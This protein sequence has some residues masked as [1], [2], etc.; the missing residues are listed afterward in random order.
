MTSSRP[1][2]LLALL[3]DAVTAAPLAPFLTDL[4]TARTWTYDELWRG[5]RHLAALLSE[6]GVAAGDRV[7]LL[8][9]NDPV[10]FP[11]LF[12]C[13]MT[14][15]ILV[16]V[17]RDNLKSELD[18]IR[19]DAKPVLELRDERYQPADGFSLPIAWRT[20]DAPAAPVAERQEDVLI[21]YTSGTTGNAKGVTLSQRNL[22]TMAG[23]FVSFYRLRPGQRF[24]SML[25]FYHI[26]A[27]MITG[28]VCIAAQ[29][30]VHL[31]D[32]YGFTNAR[33]I[34]DMVEANGINILSL[35]PSI[36][37][38][39]AQLNPSG[40]NRVTSSLE[41]CFCGTAPLSEHLWRAFETLFKVPVY[42]GYGLTETTTWATMT[43]PDARK[44]YDTV[45]VPVGCEIRI[46]GETTGE[47]LIKS[48]I[49]MRGYY[50]KKKLTRKSLC[51][52]WYHSGDV[53]YLDHDGQLVVVGRTK[54]IIKRRG[55]LI[56]P[57]AIDDSLRRSGLVLDSCT[58]GVPDELA[59]ERVVTACVLSQA[60][61]GDV[62]SYLARE[63]SP[64]MR[65]DE[66]VPVHAIPRNTVGKALPAKVRDLVTGD[67]AERVVETFTRSKISR[68]PSEHLAEIQAMI[69]TA[70]LADTRIVLVG[71]W[72]VGQRAEA[73][74]PCRR[75]M[76]RLAQLQRA[77]DAAIGHPQV[78]I[79]LLLADVHGRCNRLPDDHIDRYFKQI[80]GLAAETG[81]ETRRLSEL[82]FAAGLTEADIER[83][84]SDPEIISAWKAFPL[85][86]DF[87]RQ[88]Q[89]RC[90]GHDLAEEY[91]YRYYCTCM[92]ERQMLSEALT[93]TIFF[94]YN[95]P[96]FRVVQPDLPTLHLHSTK[97][98]TTA[99]PWFM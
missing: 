83:L 47:V 17:N 63:L 16:P 35:T 27:P 56:H 86:E 57:E 14:G 92:T 77:M 45:G 12:A 5:A 46:D 1:P 37:A 99:K 74:E 91:A 22:A 65:P 93:G 84:A 69:H 38:S 20:D 2:H 53:G 21:I 73:A 43:P 28:L 72:G 87:V 71:L 44:R 89:N 18:T 64:Y 26:N 58:V 23:N 49:V 29:A 33:T 85:R 94:T 81:L 96:K 42:Q 34:F 62:R 78:T 68:A 41:L 60:A 48:D 98:G 67:A 36:M 11:L 90:G 13:A 8:T 19:G 7:A 59:G 9:K 79:L 6:Q 3:H 15:S 88:A 40:T 50:N 25:P 97:P 82:W 55:V 70:I 31:T 80:A 52:G 10:F 4:R 76:A 54:N 61:R 32:P 66:I 39:L 30:H 95:D 51:D 75:A 24:L